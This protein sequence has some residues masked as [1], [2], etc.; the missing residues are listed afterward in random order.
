M[1]SNEDSEVT[2]ADVKDE[3]TVLAVILVNGAVILAEEGENALEIPYCKVRNAVHLI[4]SQGH[5]SFVV[6]PDGDELIGILDAIL[7]LSEF[8]GVHLNILSHL[9]LLLY[10]N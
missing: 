8:A 4:V 1:T 10:N 3:F 7:F 5:A 9:S 2:I 6:L